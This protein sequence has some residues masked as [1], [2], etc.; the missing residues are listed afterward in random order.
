MFCE[1]QSDHI[2]SCDQQIVSD[3]GQAVWSHLFLWPT[4]S[5]WNCTFCERQSC[6]IFFYDKQVVSDIAHFLKGSQ[7]ISEFPLS[8]GGKWHCTFSNG[9][10]ITSFPTTN[11][12]WVTLHI[13]MKGNLTVT[14][15][16]MTN[17]E[18][19]T[20]HIFLK[21]CL[22]ILIPTGC[23][24]WLHCIWV[25]VKDSLIT[26]FPMTNREWVTLN[27]FVTGNLIT[28]FP[29]TNREWVTLHILKTVSSHPFLKQGVSDIAHFCER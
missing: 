9:R 19:V 6:H 13:F 22:I 27:T 11:S 23:E 29:I 28:S 1:R 16:P 24:W 17:R 26:S 15:F 14:P 18:W 25:F 8:N 2:F 21:C 10:L 12:L 5:E 3:I 20:L 7:I 4:G